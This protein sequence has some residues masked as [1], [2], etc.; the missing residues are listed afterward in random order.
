MR[1][2]A[3]TRVPCF[4]MVYSVEKRVTN[5]KGNNYVLTSNRCSNNGNFKIK[6]IKHLKQIYDVQLQS[7]KK[8]QFL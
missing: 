7:N 4:K 8:I 5:V 6:V 2:F 1:F 3:N